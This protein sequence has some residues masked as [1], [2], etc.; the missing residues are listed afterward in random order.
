MLL[1]Q[2]PHIGVSPFEIHQDQARE[3]NDKGYGIFET[4][5]DFN[6]RRTKDNLRKINYWFVEIDY[7]AGVSKPSVNQLLDKFLLPTKV[8]ETKNG[9]HLYFKCKENE[10]TNIAEFSII[11]ER[12]RVKYGGDSN[13]KDVCRYLRKAGY[14]HTKDSN[15]WYMC[16]LVFESDAIYRRKFMLSLPKAPKELID[17]KKISES[18]NINPSVASSANVGDFN[19]WLSNSNQMYLLEIIS[20]SHL[21]RGDYFSFYRI[22]ADRFN[23]VTNGKPSAWFIDS[24]GR[25]GS[26]SGGGPT[27]VQFVSWYN[28]HHDG[29]DA[30]SANRKAYKDLVEFFRG[31]YE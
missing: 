24:Y 20:G 13:A 19:E 2:L 12:L 10:Y 5:N 6:G 31:S 22:G 8:V 7:P 15:D 27:V 18:L 26:S 25:I 1:A 17:L 23:S 14:Y 11:Q 4:V 29:M 9:F 16:R 30:I 21:V 28:T 3:L